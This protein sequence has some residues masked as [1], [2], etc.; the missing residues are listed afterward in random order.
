MGHMV[1]NNK[2]NLIILPSFGKKTVDLGALRIALLKTCLILFLLIP[3]LA[4]SQKPYFKKVYDLKMDDY[5]PALHVINEHQVLMFNQ[6][7]AELYDFV[8][9]ESIILPEF[10]LSFDGWKGV[11]PIVYGSDR[12]LFLDGSSICRSRVCSGFFY[13]LLKHKS[14]YLNWNLARFNQATILLKE[15]K[16]LV[17][18]G[19]IK[20]DKPVVAAE[21]VLPELLPV[22]ILT[23]DPV[24]M[25]SEVVGKLSEGRHKHTV[26]ALGESQYLVIGGTKNFG[27]SSGDDY[28]VLDI[29]LFDLSTRL[30]RVIGKLR[31]G[32][33]R[34]HVIK[35]N[36]DELL[37][38]GG[39]NF[40]LNDHLPDE[41]AGWSLCEVFNLRTGG[42]TQVKKVK[43]NESFTIADNNRLLVEVD[44]GFAYLNLNNLELE[45]YWD[46]GGHVAMTHG[47]P[48]GPTMKYKVCDKCV[49]RLFTTPDGTIFAR[50]R[51]THG[52]NRIYKLVE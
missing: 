32:R 2:L 5:S 9:N 23:L 39:N 21:D 28:P 46:W 43:R 47:S 19:I 33:I 36:E 31:H 51:E 13:D 25:K 4:C 6:S 34:P 45:D 15:G 38:V 30:T 52:E 24:S 22:E 17:I 7:K 11:T 48:Y 16:V 20:A 8:K 41:E 35:L 12:L 26:F 44:D 42:I 1:K 3:F 40:D 18:G 10:K 50:V 37:I 14:E 27:D 29:E 49:Q